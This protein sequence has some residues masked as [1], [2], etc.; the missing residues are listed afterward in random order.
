MN[1]VL[2]HMQELASH[3]SKIK[4]VRC[5]LGLGSIANHDRLDEY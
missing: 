5:L 1:K 3:V 4:E 2:K